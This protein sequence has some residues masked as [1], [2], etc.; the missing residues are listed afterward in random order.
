MIYEASWN[1][2]AGDYAVLHVDIIRWDKSETERSVFWDALVFASSS[3]LSC[4]VHRLFWDIKC[5]KPTVL[6]Y[7]TLKL[8]LLFIFIKNL[9]SYYKPARWSSRSC[10]CHQILRWKYSLSL[11]VLYI[12]FLRENFH[13]CRIWD[14]KQ[15]LY[16]TACWC[17]AE[18]FA[19]VAYYKYS[20]GRE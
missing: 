13:S 2:V 19:E 8:Y 16:V 4:Y 6:C 7:V 3:N 5:L 15:V 10:S 11:Y 9:E 12:K 14:G 18:P 1:T 17:K 20:P